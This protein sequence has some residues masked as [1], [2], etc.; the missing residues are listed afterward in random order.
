MGLGRDYR[1]DFK[2]STKFKIKYHKNCI[3]A[4]KEKCS[5]V[6]KAEAKVV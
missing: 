1:R 3:E 5:T 6:R 2:Y 4:V